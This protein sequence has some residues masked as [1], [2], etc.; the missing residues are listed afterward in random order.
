VTIG[1]VA[2]NPTAWS[3]TSITVAVPSGAATGNVVVTVGA[4]TANSAITVA[5]GGVVI[6]DVEGGS[7][8]TWPDPTTG[9][10]QSG[11]Y[12][13]GTGVT[14]DNSSITTDGPQAAALK[15]GARGMRVQ[16]SYL[17]GWGGG[18]GAT[19]A[20]TLDLSSYD[21]ISFYVAWDGSSNDV[22]I[23]LKDS[24]GTAFA[25]TI[26]N[27]TLT[28]VSGYGKVT[29]NKTAFSHDADGSDPGSDATPNWA[30]V[31]NYS[32]GY[33]TTGTATGY[34]YID[35]ISA[36]NVDFGGTDEV[37]VSEVIIDSVTPPAGP[38]GTQVLISG[39]GFGAAQGQSILILENLDS[40]ITY[41]LEVLSWSETSI[42][43][44]VP[45]LAP[46]GNYRM[47]V[48]KI[49]VTAGTMQAFES[50]PAGFRVTAIMSSAG[51][52]TIFPNP[53]NPLETSVPATRAS[54]LPASA[55]TIAYNATGI[56]NIGIYVY[57]ATARLVYHTVTNTNQV[58]WDGRD[59]QG[60]LVGD[61]VY[62]LRV[63]NEESKSTIAKGK[64]L[65]IKR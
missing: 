31:K 48:I 55:A 9:L 36:G 17:S 18:W 4:D 30:A 64:I 47:K 44:I 46:A 50:N 56:T 27:I 19:L 60:N 52:A 51:I 45:R 25:A 10:A 5:A 42:E 61:G 49:A 53:F 20:N 59:D 24:D 21:T 6:D 7:V 57:D 65:V 14:P 15:H 23:S 43:A 40:H 12:A 2:G 13:F 8:G 58:S 26:S 22:K 11:Y 41:Q 28:S 38:A 16:Y 62:L 1:G 33:P 37:E 54:G 34:Q 29:V 32:I 63:V 39:E 3:A 35:S